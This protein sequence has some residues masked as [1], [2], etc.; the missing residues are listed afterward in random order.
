MYKGKFLLSGLFGIVTLL[1][2]SFS[3]QLYSQEDVIKERKKIMK[4]NNKQVK[5]IKKALV[6]KDFAT[7]ESSAKVI[8]GNMD[9]VLDLFPKGSTS[10]KSRAKSEIWKKW[11]EFSEIRDKEKA[12]AGALAK[13]AAAKD[14]AEV[15]VQAKAVGEFRKGACGNCHKTFLKPKKK[16]KK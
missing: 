10:E 4:S 6:E 2:F 13:A 12:A 9:K 14:E 1:I 15:E 11:D 16:K 3:S 5:T 7:I 8:V